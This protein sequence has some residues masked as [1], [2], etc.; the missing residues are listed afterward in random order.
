M[1]L[2]FLAGVLVV[3][4]LIPNGCRTDFVATSSNGRPDARSKTIPNSENA[5]F[6]YVGRSLTAKTREADQARSMMSIKSQLELE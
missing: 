1:L 5:A 3:V 4:L 6:E 2:L